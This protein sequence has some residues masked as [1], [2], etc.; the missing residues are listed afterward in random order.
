MPG[1]MSILLRIVAYP[2]SAQVLRRQAAA[3]IC[4]SIRWAVLAMVP[5]LLRAH[6]GAGYVQMLVATMAGSVLMVLSIFWAELYRG[7]QTRRYVWMF[8]L[9]GVFPMVGIALSRSATAAVIWLVIACVASSGMTP[10]AGDLLRACY[11][12]QLR[13]RV[14]AVLNVASLLATA[15]FAYTIGRWLDDDERAF[16]IYMPVAVAIHAVGTALLASIARLPLFIDRQRAVS[17]ARLRRSPLEPIR[18]MGRVLRSDA[19]FYRYE[20]AFMSYGLGWMICQPLLPLLVIDKLHLSYEQVAVSTQVAF[21]VTMLLT[22][23]PMGYLIDRLGPA[24]TCALA[25]GWLTIYPI[26]LMLATGAAAL[27]VVTV[28]YAVGMAAMNMGW[29]IGPVSLARQAAEAPLYASIHSTLVG[30]RGLLGQP[31]GMGL[32]VLSGS[33]AVP[34]FAATAAFAWGGYR[35]YVLARDLREPAEGFGLA[36]AETGLA[37]AP[38]PGQADA[39]VQPRGLTGRVSMES[40]AAGA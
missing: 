40:E 30:F 4:L 34:L 17:G 6:F 24:R 29:M 14:W 9:V 21:Q 5:V 1:V 35:M 3:S 10:M 13:G 22:T 2:E 38:N 39:A 32:Y 31:L 27:T 25:F 15:V 33:F 16:R 23:L 8:W 7:M 12:P 26:G 11:S 28:A 18:Q 36:A 37:A 19:Y 20:V